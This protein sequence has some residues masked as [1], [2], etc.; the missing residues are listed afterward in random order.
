MCDINIVGKAGPLEANYASLVHFCANEATKAD[1]GISFIQFQFT[2]G[3]VL[4]H[5]LYRERHRP[6]YKDNDFFKLDYNELVKAQVK[7]NKGK[8][9]DITI[10]FKHDK[11]YRIEIT[12]YES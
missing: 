6:M 4:D 1:H 5:S 9:Q 11:F 10:Y 12:N 8:I 3:G 2:R 7:K